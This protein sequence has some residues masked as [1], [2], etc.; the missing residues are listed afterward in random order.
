MP[1]YCNNGNTAVA[2][3]LPLT[4]DYADLLREARPLLDV[5]A[6][7]EFSEG[8]LP[9]AR[10]L[11][12][13][14]DREREQVGIRYKEA[15]QAAAIELGHELVGG[16]VRDARIAQWVDFVNRHPDARLYC[17]R[18]GLRSRIAQ[19]WLHEAGVTI[20]RVEGGYKSLRRFVLDEL[21]ESLIPRLP[22]LVVAGRTGT[23]KTRFLHQLPNPVDLEGLA[24]HRGS[25]FGR[26]L[27]PQPTQASF[28]NALAT[29][30]YQAHDRGGPIH[31]ED[32][33]RL[34]GRR[35]LPVSLQNR[36][37]ASPRIMLEQP[38]ET[39]V[40]NILEDYVIDMSQAFMDRDGPEAGFEAFREFLLDALGRI[41]KRLGGLR[42]QQLESVMR[43]ALIRQWQSGD[44]ERH[45]DWIRT[46]LTDYYDPM[47]DYQL[48]QGD[49]RVL[50]QG[51]FEELIEWASEAGSQ[52]VIAQFTRRSA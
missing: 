19:E 50:K 23:G 47:Y 22:L 18:G 40:E 7:V 9:H 45:R 46:L 52:H 13:M 4:D 15:G 12:L 25:S 5:R 32:E 31:V 28:E 48:G 29:A 38:F 17:S 8:T 36:L 30:L 24:A 6:P 11:P 35:M 44:L 26:T 21:I 37:A 51:G 10:N 20:P 3:E 34:I 14:E 33:G 27:T 2:S 16:E 49:G 43:D 39:R 42:H 1:F 41:R